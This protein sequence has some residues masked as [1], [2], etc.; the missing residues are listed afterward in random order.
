MRILASA[1]CVLAILCAPLCIASQAAE[2]H[3]IANKCLDVSGGSSANG[4]PI[5]LYVCKGAP[6][7]ANQVWGVANGAIIG[8]GNKCLDVKGGS[9]ADGTPIIL[10]GCTGNANQQWTISHGQI[11]GLENKC[12]DVS[13]GGSADGTPIILYTCKTP[14][15][16][17]NQLWTV[18]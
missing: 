17:A 11:R 1:I 3:G 14:P 7:N 4:T 13:G 18:R 8:I 5:I 6:N 9:S 2:I 16:N 12:L 15:N 10:Y